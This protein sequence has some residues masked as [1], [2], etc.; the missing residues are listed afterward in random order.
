MG[1]RATE[2][3]TA[4][5]QHL[6]E[7]G[8]TNEDALALGRTAVAGPSWIVADRQVAGRGRQG[9]LWQS[10][11]GN[12]YAT[13]LVP[14]DAPVSVLPQLSHVAAVALVAALE[15]CV[16][17]QPGLRIKWPNDVLLDGAKLAGILVEGT[18]TAAG[19]QVCALGFGVNCAN[20]PEALP[21]RATSLAT[22][23]GETT[24]PEALFARLRLRVQAAFAAW[25]D[26]RGYAAIRE[27]WLAHALPLDTALVVRGARDPIHGRFQ[28]IDDKGRL[29]LMGPHGPVTVEAGDVTL[30]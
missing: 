26:G 7:T 20:F 11:V 5:V 19:Q 28:G 9:R 12:L 17:A 4:P 27:R 13:L 6:A 2:I 10:P 23:F 14:V 21:Y 25:D 18:R 29:L 1:E 3:D 22:V 15:D 8:S 24:P 16:G 30:N